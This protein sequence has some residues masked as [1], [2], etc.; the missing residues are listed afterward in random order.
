MAKAA[1]RRCRRGLMTKE[2][3]VGFIAAR[4]C[5]LSSTFCVQLVQVVDVAVAHVLPHE[6]DVGRRVVRV[7]RRHVEVVH[8]VDE[9]LVAGRAE[10]LARLLLERRLEIFWN[11][12]ELV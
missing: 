12:F 8:K 11:M 1:K 4:Y 10:V 6:R 2:P 5:V 9:L 7:E 3:A